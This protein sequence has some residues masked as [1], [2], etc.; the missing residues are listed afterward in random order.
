MDVTGLLL[1]LFGM[2]LLGAEVMVPSFGV[3]GIGGSS[4][5]SPVR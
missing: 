2:A 1:V 5:C 3:L 4:P